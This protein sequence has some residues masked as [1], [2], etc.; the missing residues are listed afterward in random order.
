MRAWFEMIHLREYE[1]TMAMVLYWGLTPETDLFTTT[2]S[3][4]TPLRA[5]ENKPSIVTKH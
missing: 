2:Q 3:T 1:S 4:M 5:N